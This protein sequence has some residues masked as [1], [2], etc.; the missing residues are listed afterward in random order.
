MNQAVAASMSGFA[1]P[2]FWRRS[3]GKSRSVGGT[4][5]CVSLL[6]PTRIPGRFPTSQ[7]S[8]VCRRRVLPT[9]ISVGA[10]V[11]HKI[12]DSVEI[13]DSVADLE[14]AHFR[15]QA[16]G[17]LLGSRSANNVGMISPMSNCDTL[18]G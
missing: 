17:V 16:A 15:R 3:D 2:S 6:D 1:R 4:D 18:V 13:L 8:L 14:Q 5:R 9:G 11:F 10:A 12:L 7:A